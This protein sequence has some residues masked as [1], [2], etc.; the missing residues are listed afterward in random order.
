M[1]G[2]GFLELGV[3][4]ELAALVELHPVDVLDADVLAAGEQVEGEFPCVVSLSHASVDC[5]DEALDGVL[6]GSGRVADALPA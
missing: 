1:R 6:D 5:E 3:G 4:V 2:D